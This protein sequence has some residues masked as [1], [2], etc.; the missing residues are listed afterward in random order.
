MRIAPED[1]PASL[2]QT[3]YMANG[4]SKLQCIYVDQQHPL[5][6]PEVHKVNMRTNLGHDSI[7]NGYINSS[8]GNSFIPSKEIGQM[9]PGSVCIQRGRSCT[10]TLIGFETITIHIQ[11][12]Y[13]VD[14]VCLLEVLGWGHSLYLVRLII[15]LLQW[16]FK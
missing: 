9:P 8:W 3:D 16:C 1:M 13:R 15:G 4:S 6:N 11:S 14:T 5:P 12:K 7:K 2:S 10:R